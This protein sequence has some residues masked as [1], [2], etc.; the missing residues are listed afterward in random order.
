MGYVIFLQRCNGDEAGPPASFARQTLAKP[1]S[2]P[3]WLSARNSKLESL[4]QQGS[5]SRS[6]ASSAQG[7][8]TPPVPEASL[9]A[10]NTGSVAS[11]NVES[12]PIASP[13]A[14]QRRTSA[15]KRL[16]GG[17]ISKIESVT[18]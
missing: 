6:F 2:W 16:C 15:C 4:L 18:H 3:H 9:L 8:H 1:E 5:G 17:L 13:G 10:E 12:R 11:L 14:R 7:S